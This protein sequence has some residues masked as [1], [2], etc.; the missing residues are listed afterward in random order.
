MAAFS[1]FSWR[2]CDEV[3]S[4]GSS[5]SSS[6]MPNI[7]GCDPNK[8]LFAF[9]ELVVPVGSLTGCPAMAYGTHIL[10]NREFVHSGTLNSSCNLGCG[11]ASIDQAAGQTGT[12]FLGEPLYDTP[13]YGVGCDVAAQRTCS[14]IGSTLARVIWNLSIGGGSVSLWSPVGGVTFANRYTGSIGG[15][16]STI[17]VANLSPPTGFP[18]SLTLTATG[19]P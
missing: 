6:L 16:A 5:V 17:T 15:S 18:T 7:T 14:W 3:S 1:G 11:W 10:A 12:G 13:V 4:S 9:Y 8:Q 2:C 19:A